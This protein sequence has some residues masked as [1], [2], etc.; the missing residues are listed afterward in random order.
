MSRIDDLIRDLCPDGVEYKPLGEVGRLL[1]GLTGK[2]KAD[3]VDGTARYVSYKNVYS[4]LEVDVTADDFV[5]I[6]DSET[7]NALQIGDI[8]FT[9]SSENR[10]EVGLTSVI[11][12]LPPEPLYLNSFCICFRPTEIFTLL[13]E[14]AKH[15]FRS[16]AIRHQIIKTATGVTRIN[17]S[18]K[19][20][21]KT[22]VPLPPVEVQQEVARILDQ[23]TQLERNLKDELEAR[24]EQLQHFRSTILNNPSFPQRDVG[25]LVQPQPVPS[26]LKRSNYLTNGRHPVIDQGHT[27]IAGY[28]N[29]NSLALNFGPC[30]IFGDHTRAIKYVDFT[31]V[32]GAEGVRPLLPL[33]DIDP[34]YL[35][36]ALSNLNIP[37]RGYNRHWTILSKMKMPVPPLKLQL[38]IV[39]TLDKFDSLINDPI[40]GLPAEIEARRKQYEYYRDRL[41]TFPEK[42]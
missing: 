27:R 10:E 22:Q 9:G 39:R 29:D 2:T 41:L 35:F 5:R 1:G 40:F 33:K 31:F 17:I 16:G 6:S 30:V 8:L 25:E 19:N 23:P 15:L 28:C 36:H 37:S 12:S 20:L 32:P 11:T 21:A 26:G 4:N 18:R 3:F 42:K 24:I 34:R 7:Q 38:D 13:P 14:F